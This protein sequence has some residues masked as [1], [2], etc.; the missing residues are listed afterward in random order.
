M[1]NRVAVQRCRPCWAR[2]AHQLCTAA[3]VVTV[4]STLAARAKDETTACVLALAQTLVV[5]RHLQRLDRDVGVKLDKITCSNPAVVGGGGGGGGG[6]GSGGAS[7]LQ[8]CL[9]PADNNLGVLVVNQTAKLDCRL[10]AY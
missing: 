4:G 5:K 10:L 6:G 2:G 7:S 3:A 1:R 8:G 9:L